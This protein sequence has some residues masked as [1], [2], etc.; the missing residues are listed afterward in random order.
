MFS[1]LQVPQQELFTAICMP[2]MNAIFHTSHH[3]ICGEEYKLWI[4][5]L[6]SV[7]TLLSLPVVSKCS[8]LHL[9]L[10]LSGLL[11]IQ[12]FQDVTRR[13]LGLL[14]DKYLHC[15]ERAAQ[16]MHNVRW[17]CYSVSSVF[18][19]SNMTTLGTVYC[20]GIHLFM[21]CGYLSPW[22]DVSSGC[23]WRRGLPDIRGRCQYTE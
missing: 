15:G 8:A 16:I 23:R 4:S 9:T 12:V 13:C 14:I 7:S 20:V 2:F 11:G 1:C 3:D 19:N 22:H 17:T 6:C 10:H 21:I 18:H 5:L